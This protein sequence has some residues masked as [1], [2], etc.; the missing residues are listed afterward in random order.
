MSAICDSSLHEQLKRTSQM[1]Y[2][3]KPKRRRG[4]SWGWEQMELR[5][6]ASFAWIGCLP[7]VNHW[8]TLTLTHGWCFRQTCENH[9]Q[10]IHTPFSYLD[11]WL[12][13]HTV[14]TRTCEVQNTTSSVCLTFC[15]FWTVAWNWR[16]FVNPKGNYFAELLMFHVSLS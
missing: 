11:L 6:T 4:G 14:C 9:I 10:F 5:S 7:W 1:E 15:C 13:R 3:T 2:P 16:N 12:T 8:T